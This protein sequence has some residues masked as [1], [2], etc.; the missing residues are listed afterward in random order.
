MSYTSKQSQ[1]HNIIRRNK[2][3]IATMLH[4][5]FYSIKN[6]QP[7]NIVDTRVL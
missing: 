4:R 7:G 3:F 6:T 1:E 5:N 2:I